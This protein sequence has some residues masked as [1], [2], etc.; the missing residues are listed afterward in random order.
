[1]VIVLFRLQSIRLDDVS[2]IRSIFNVKKKRK[3]DYKPFNPEEMIERMKEENRTGY[4]DPNLM[5]PSWPG[6]KKTKSEEKTGDE[7]MEPFTE[8]GDEKTEPFTEKGDEKM[9]PI[10]K[11]GDEELIEKLNQMKC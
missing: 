1:M 10:K 5:F 8:K 2:I 11:K 6:R 4:V 7:K 9:K 3:C